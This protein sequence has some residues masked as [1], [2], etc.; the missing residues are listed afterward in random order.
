[1]Y[2]VRRHST[3]VMYQVFRPVQYAH[4]ARSPLLRTVGGRDT[5]GFSWVREGLEYNFVTL[6]KLAEQRRSAIT[7]QPSKQHHHVKCLASNNF[8]YY[9]CPQIS[10]SDLEGRGSSTRASALTP[11]G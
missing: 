10:G 4:L 11:T 1:M 9:I 6:G 8:K 2:Q 3:D 7:I 5:A